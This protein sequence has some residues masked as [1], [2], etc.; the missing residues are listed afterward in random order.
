MHRSLR[1]PKRR[2]EWV[3]MLFS[4]KAASLGFTVTRP[5]GDCA[6]Y[7][8]ILEKSGRLFRIQ[9]KS[10]Y[11]KTGLKGSYH[12]RLMSNHGIFLYNHRT[13]DFM[14]VYVIPE[15]VWY[16]MP[17]SAVAHVKVAFVLSPSQKGHKYERFME[18]WCLLDQS[19]SK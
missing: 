10:T 5:W 16:I 2:G 1:L 19:I 11:N 18:A 8:V 17:I 15:D 13:V 6:R 9:I 4:A 7:D 14:A 12:C 3:E